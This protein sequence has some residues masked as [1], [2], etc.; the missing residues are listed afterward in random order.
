MDEPDFGRLPS[1]MWGKQVRENE[2]WGQPARATLLGLGD[3]K[4]AWGL[5]LHWAKCALARL[6]GGRGGP[7]VARRT[8]ADRG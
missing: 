1:S 8:C 6:Q 3:L 4:A 5:I 7:V 2:L